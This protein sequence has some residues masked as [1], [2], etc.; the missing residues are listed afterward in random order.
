MTEAG[1]RLAVACHGVAHALDVRIQ[2]SHMGLGADAP[3]GHQGVCEALPA[4]GEVLAALEQA[5]T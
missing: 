3:L 5:E 2:D 4:V 1:Q